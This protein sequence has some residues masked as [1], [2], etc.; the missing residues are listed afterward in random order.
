MNTLVFG[1]ALE[2]QYFIEDL[3]V[4]GFRK[5]NS[6]SSSTAFSY[7]SSTYPD[8]RVVVNVQH[9]TMDLYVK[10]KIVQNA[11]TNASD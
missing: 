6:R 11:T 10:E 3:H 9:L 7:V 1:D 5:D 4:R 8:T 2:C